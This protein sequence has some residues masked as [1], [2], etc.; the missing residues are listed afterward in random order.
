MRIRELNA[1]LGLRWSPKQWD[2]LTFRSP[3]RP[4]GETPVDIVGFLGDYGGGKTFPAAARF[5]ACCLSN[6]FVHGEHSGDDPPMSGLAAPTLGDLK[7]A[8]WIAIKKVLGPVADNIIVKER[9]Y[10]EYQDVELVNGHRILFYS[11]NGATNGPTLCQFWAD[12]I[13]ENAFEGRWDNYLGRVR[14]ERATWLNLQVS[15]LATRGYVEDLFRDKGDK[16]NMR[17]VLLFAEDNPRT[18]TGWRDE[19]ALLKTRERDEDGWLMPEGVLYPTFSKKRN[20]TP[21]PAVAFPNRLLLRRWPMSLSFDFGRG[22]AVAWFTPWTVPVDTGRKRP[23]LRRG[24]LFTD[25]IMPDEREAEEVV[26][27]AA[28]RPWLIQRRGSV[29]CVDPTAQVD[30]IN[31]IKRA[32]PGVPI[33]QHRDGFYFKNDNGERAVTRALRDGRGNVLLYILPELIE[34]ESGRG[35]VKM[36]SDYRTNRRKD[37]RYEHAADVVRYAVQ[38]TLPLAGHDPIFAPGFGER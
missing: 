31:H 7:K 16:P 15:G 14:D 23:E 3:P 10:G 12:E 11:A 29:I 37:Q 27:M 38:H 34:D 9:L 28:A 32:F 36:F 8:P 26:A 1:D 21:P 5:L 6:G 35:I 30:Q 19:M 25:Q 22:A 20:M 13:Q 33:I 24:I 2:A 18:A 4:D 17:T